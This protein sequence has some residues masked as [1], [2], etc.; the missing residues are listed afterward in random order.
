MSS[1]SGHFRYM[2][3]DFHSV[4]LDSERNLFCKIH[5]WCLQRHKRKAYFTSSSYPFFMEFYEDRPE[6]FRI[7]KH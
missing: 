4:Y 1:E 2:L 7:N 5:T 3:H 6:N